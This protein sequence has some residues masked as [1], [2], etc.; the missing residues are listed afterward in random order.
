ML[1]INWTMRTLLAVGFR[2]LARLAPSA[3]VITIAILAT[4]SANPADGDDDYYK[5][6]QEAVQH[7]PAHVS[8]KSCFV[9]NDGPK[10]TPWRIIP[11]TGCAHWVAHEKGIR[12][13]E[14]TCDAGCAIRVSDVIGSKSFYTLPKAK[15]GDI[16]TN[17]TRTHCGIVTGVRQDKKGKAIVTVRHCSSGQGGVTTSSFSDGMVW[18]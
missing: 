14:A 15:V 7:V 9:W 2:V 11:G 8:P 4:L 17:L 6:K 3:L 16:W 13:G 5:T 18:R 12:G 1:F 10:A